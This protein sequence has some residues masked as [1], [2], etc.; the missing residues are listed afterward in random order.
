MEWDTGVKKHARHRANYKSQNSGCESEVLVFSNV[1]EYYFKLE[2]K[3][4]LITSPL[5][6][7]AIKDSFASQGAMEAKPDIAQ[8]RKAVVQVKQILCIG[9]CLASHSDQKLM[10]RDA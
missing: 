9:L 8:K 10:P 3:Q 4:A 5:M 6:W 2:K 1:I 7:I